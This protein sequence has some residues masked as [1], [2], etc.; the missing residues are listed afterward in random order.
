MR[1]T[2][3]YLSELK[4]IVQ[5]GI[6]FPRKAEEKLSVFALKLDMDNEEGETDDYEIT[7]IWLDVTDQFRKR[8]KDT[9][10]ELASSMYQVMKEFLDGDISQEALDN[11][12][13]NKFVSDTFSQG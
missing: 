11:F 13:V 1:Q 3:D 6:S 5:L 7:K 9:S 2:N 8:I 4:D 12:S 10:D